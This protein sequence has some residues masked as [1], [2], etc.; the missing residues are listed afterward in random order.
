MEGFSVWAG[1]QGGKDVGAA[2]AYYDAYMASL[3]GWNS[4]VDQ[5][6]Q[7]GHVVLWVIVAPLYI[8]REV[9]TC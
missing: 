9:G 8:Q 3:N 5:I 6:I 2:I 1:L 7:A 4:Q